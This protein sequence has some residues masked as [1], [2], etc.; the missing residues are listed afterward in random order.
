MFDESQS[1]TPQLARDLIAWTRA[2]FDRVVA[3]NFV[4]PPYYP[5]A[6]TVKRL[7]GYFHA[8]LSPAEA[9]EACFGTKH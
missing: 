1:L 6:T 8:G 5:D 7:Q 2:W 3:A 9:A 4:R